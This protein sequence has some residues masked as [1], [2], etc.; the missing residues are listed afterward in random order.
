MTKIATKQLLEKK[1]YKN[2]S[3]IGSKSSNKGF[4]I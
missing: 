3:I 4:F 2:L 1:L